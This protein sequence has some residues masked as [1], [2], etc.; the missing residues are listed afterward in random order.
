MCLG[1]QIATHLPVVAVEN[2]VHVALVVG[3]RDNCDQQ[4]PE[5]EE[6]EQHVRIGDASFVF[7][8]IIFPRSH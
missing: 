4:S 8:D 2:E 3:V 1:G 7:E 6:E 5:D